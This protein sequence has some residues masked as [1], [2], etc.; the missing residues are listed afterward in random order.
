M[1]PHIEDLPVIL[2]SRADTV[3]AKRLSASAADLYPNALARDPVG[4][5][6]AIGV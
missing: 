3:T 4:I 5:V 2:I 1:L 6:P